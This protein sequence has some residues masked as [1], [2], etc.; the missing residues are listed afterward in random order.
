MVQEKVPQLQGQISLASSL[1]HSTSL[2]SIFF[3]SAMGL[4]ISAGRVQDEVCSTVT[5][6]QA[7]SLQC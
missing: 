6:S 2:N 3:P 1:N 4:L 5:G 7:V